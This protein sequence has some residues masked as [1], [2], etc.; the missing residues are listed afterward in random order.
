MERTFATPGHVLVNVEN[1]VGLV[2]ITGVEGSTTSVS[3]EA[4]P[5]GAEE[6][7]QRAVVECQ[8]AGDRDVVRVRIP[9]AHGMKFVRRNGVTVRIDMPSGG[10]VDVKTAS[11][12]VELNGTVGGVSVKSASGDV[13]ADYASGDVHIATASG[14]LSVEGVGGN[15][16]MHTASGDARAVKVAG[17]VAVTNRSGDIEVGSAGDGADIRTASG[18]IRVGELAGDSSVAG[19][20]GDVRVLSFESGHLQIRAVSGDISVG[21]PHGTSFRVDAESLSG[22][23]RSEIPLDDSAPSGDGP[24][25][26]VVAR[27]VSGDFLVERAVG[28]LVP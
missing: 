7:L 17:G 26:S 18:D 10:D 28:A 13:T 4:A 3:L 9:H 5:A 25:V 15:L 2:V 19:V 20:S 11:A 23:V 27:T 14:D 12:D 8:K 22:S 16:R 24:R 6:L 21:I 1:D